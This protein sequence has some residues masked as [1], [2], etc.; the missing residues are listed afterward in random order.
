M[1][2][3]ALLDGGVSMPARKTLGQRICLWF[4]RRLATRHANAH[5]HPTCMISPE[6]RVHPRQ[7][8]IELGSD[9]TIALGALVQGNVRMGSH[10]SVQAYS[11]LIGY[12]EA[13]DATGRITIGN[14]V[15]IAPYVAM[16]ATNHRFDRMDVPI[17]SQGHQFGAIT[18]GDDVW[19]GAHVIVTAGVTIGSGSVIGA[20]SVVTHDI[21]PY[22]VAVGAPARVIKQ[23]LADAT[24]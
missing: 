19:I 10:C 15:R 23:R 9:C 24:G 20:G 17:R 3:W 2:L 7:G 18:I 22:S 21:P 13:D 11:S 16:I 8:R 5:I 4:G 12:G 1:S 6:A 14:D